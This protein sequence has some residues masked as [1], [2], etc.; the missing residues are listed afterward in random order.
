MYV[1]KTNTKSHN[2]NGSAK[3]KKFRFNLNSFFQIQIDL[4][5]VFVSKSTKKTIESFSKQTKIMIYSIQ[6]YQITDR[7]L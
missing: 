4:N 3:N 5:D 2:K 1:T 7:L 6:A